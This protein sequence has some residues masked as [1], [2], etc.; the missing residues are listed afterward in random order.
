MIA[1]YPQYFRL[2]PKKPLACVEVGPLV[3]APMV[4]TVR[5]PV[6][7]TGRPASG[8]VAS[9]SRL[10]GWSHETLPLPSL[11]AVS[12]YRIIA[13]RPTPPISSRI[14]SGLHGSARHVRR[15]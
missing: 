11:V 15:V 9:T 14:V 7:H 6:P 10:S 12:R 8:P 5:P 4:H 2:V 3:P 1:S 13:P